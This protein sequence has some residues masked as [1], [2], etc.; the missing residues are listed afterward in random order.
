[1]AALELLKITRGIDSR[2]EGVDK[3]VQ[4]LH[5]KVGGVDDQMRSVDGRVGLVI[6]GIFISP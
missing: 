5:S 6:E 1:M 2:V 4:V 3:R